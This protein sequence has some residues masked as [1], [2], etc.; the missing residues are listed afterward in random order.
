MKNKLK[1][2]LLDIFELTLGLAMFGCLFWL[3]CLMVTGQVGASDVVMPVLK[4]DEVYYDSNGAS[5][6]GWE[7]EECVR[8]LMLEAGG[9]SEADIREHAAIYC[10]QLLYTQTVGGYDDWGTSL[11]GVVHSHGYA[12]TYPYIWTERATPTDY[13]RSIFWDVWT[14]GYS[15]DFRVQNFRSGWYHSP[16]WSIPM[17][18]IG[19][20]FYSI[21]IW[22]DFS[23]FNLDENGQ[24]VKESDWFWKYYSG[25]VEVKM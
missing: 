18:Q 15:S 5:A 17:Y 22:Q 8:E 6:Y 19:E 12:E 20:T 16:A 2:I 7:L 3:F 23:M 4:N 13:V 1:I 11:W 24:L 14:N 9:E 21:N 10:K 25:S